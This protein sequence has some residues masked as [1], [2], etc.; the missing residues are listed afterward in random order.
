MPRIEVTGIGRI[1]DVVRIADVDYTAVPEA[2]KVRLRLIAAPINPADLLTIDGRYGV[3]PPPPFTPGSEA[4]A[5]VVA[6]GEGVDGLAVGDAVL[7]MP[8]GGLWADPLELPARH[9]IRLPEG[10]DAEQAA[11][12]KGTLATARLLVEESGLGA[13]DWLVQNAANSAVGT[14][15]ARVAKR[16]GIRTLGIVRGEAAAEVARAAGHDAVLVLAN[17]GADAAGLKAAAMPILGEAGARHALDAVGGGAGG[18]LTGLLAPGSRLVNYGLLSGKPL[19]VPAEALVFGGV[20]VTGFWLLTWFRSR[21]PADAFALFNRLLSDMA[22]HGP[23]LDLAIEARYPIAQG[24]EALLHAAR[25]GRSG[26]VLLT[27]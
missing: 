13:G 11:M 12:L 10:V 8:G 21:S 19:E 22:E 1:E 25:E 17:A 4:T 27:A 24:V 3:I 2:G 16:A 14:S 9:V 5:R 7:I 23:V 15:V 18:A 26:K 6:V 20:T